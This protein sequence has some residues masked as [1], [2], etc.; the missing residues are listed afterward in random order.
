MGSFLY[1]FLGS[2]LLYELYKSAKQEAD[3]EELDPAE[4]SAKTNSIL[5]ILIQKVCQECSVPSVIINSRLIQEFKTKIWRLNQALTKAKNMGGN[6]VRRVFSQWT[7]GQFSTWS[8]KIYYNG[9]GCAR[10][11]NENNDL[12][13]QKRKLEDDLK[14]ERCKKAKI[15]QKLKEAVTKNKEI[16]GKFQKNFKWLVQKLM[17]L[18]KDEKLRGPTKN[19]TF[20]DCSKKHQTRVQSKWPQTVKHH[21]HSLGFIIL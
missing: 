4:S 15:E 20:S 3:S 7:N 10:L 6:G 19:K 16:T 21:C 17:K 5:K 14:E 18:Q 12:R 8:F 2:I 9:M 11:Q 13:G 1:V